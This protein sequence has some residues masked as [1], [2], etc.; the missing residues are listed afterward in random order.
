MVL[1]DKSG[2]I[3]ILMQMERE[4]DEVKRERDEVKRERDV[5]LSQLEVTK[6]QVGYQNAPLSTN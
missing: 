1:M 3:Q 5:A 2:L 6:L 4:M